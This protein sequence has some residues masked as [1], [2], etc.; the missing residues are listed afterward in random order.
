M[1]AND[2]LRSTASIA[3]RKGREVNWPAFQ[4]RVH[5]VLEHQHRLMYPPR[6]LREAAEHGD[7][8]AIAV[9][10]DP[11]EPPIPGYNTE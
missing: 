8:M 4:R 9:L 1:E 6:T 5:R 3:D 11:P 2:I 7:P 10:A